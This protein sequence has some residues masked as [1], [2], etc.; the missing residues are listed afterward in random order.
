MA[1]RRQH[2]DEETVREVLKK[3]Q[4]NNIEVSKLVEYRKDYCQQVESSTEGGSTA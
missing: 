4:E 2:P 1:F 3:L